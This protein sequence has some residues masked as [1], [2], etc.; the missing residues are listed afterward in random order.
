M[1][2]RLACALGVVLA[3]LAAASCGTAVTG[4][5]PPGVRAGLDWTTAE[6]ERPAG[7]GSDPS[8]TAA[9]PA[10]PGRAGHPG[11]FQGQAYMVDVTAGAGR[12]VAVGY[13]YPGWHATAWSSA[14]G[15]SWQLVPIEG[16]D[17]E[18]FIDAVAAG[19]DRLVAFG[20]R[21]RR[22][23][24]WSS[25]DGASWAP[26]PDGVPA[27]DMTE[28][29]PGTAVATPQGFSAGGCSG[30]GTEPAEAR[31]WWS[32][33]GMTWNASVLD[34]ARDGRVASIA[35]GPDG[36]VAIGTSGPLATPTGSVAWTSADGTEWHKVPSGAVLAATV[37]RSVTWHE[38]GFV[39][40]GEAIDGHRASVLRSADGLEWTAVAD[41][42]AF[43]Y[44]D[45]PIRMA[46]VAVAPSGLVVVGHHLFGTQFGN[47]TAWV[48][49]EGSAWER[50][51]PSPVFP[52]GEMEAV[53]AAG[54]DIVA[55]GTYGAP[56]NH[57]P[58]VWISPP[59]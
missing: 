16:A 59:P 12:L 34:D 9:A 57:V 7:F 14:D 22:P 46:D 28:A 48:S 36:L 33:D 10:G 5:V 27:E 55:V 58:T 37:L 32:P 29:C 42:P 35:P 47:A 52:Q 11:H 54:E 50:A 3:S 49:D 45:Q 26:V 18:S 53:V 21:G 41:Q 19:A 51:G 39:A 23:A 6:V 1:T 13:A 25:A 44:H 24:A 56:D 17:E 31:F 30:P 15:R 38:D 43:S 20:R 2:G 40:V 4:S 8:A